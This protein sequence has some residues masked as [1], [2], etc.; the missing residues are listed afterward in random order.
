MNSELSTGTIVGSVNRLIC[1]VIECTNL[2]IWNPSIRKFKKLPDFRPR[3]KHCFK[4]DFQGRRYCSGRGF[5][6]I[7]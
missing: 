3:Y 6:R 5:G 7:H 2:F 4:C 1:F